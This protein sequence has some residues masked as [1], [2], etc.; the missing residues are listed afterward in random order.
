[1]AHRSRPTALALFAALTVTAAAIAQQPHPA[2][3]GRPTPNLQPAAAPDP[4]RPPM[5]I[6][7]V[8]FAGGTVQEFVKVIQK[9]AMESTAKTPVNVM[10]PTEAGA[11]SLPAISLKR[12]SAE[13]AL[14]T[15]R[16]AFGVQGAHQLEA[17][18]M[19]N[20]GDEGLTFA[21]QYAPGRSSPQMQGVQ[22]QQP[23]QSEA[24]S[25]REL[26]SVPEGL[27][28]DNDSLRMTPDAVLGAL[29]LAAELESVNAT[30]TP[31]QLLYHPDTQLLIA[32]GTPDQHRLISSILRQLA[33]MLEQ[34]RDQHGDELSRAHHNELQILE[35]K[36]QAAAA[37][38]QVQRA[39]SELGPAT[40]ELER[41]EKLFQAGS[42]SASEVERA[43]ANLG[44]A[45]ANLQG[46]EVQM[47]TLEQRAEVLQRKAKAD[48]MPAE[49]QE[50]IVVIYDVRDLANFKADFYGL[51]KQVI[52]PDGKMSIKAASGDPTG[53]IVVHA[54]RP[55]HEILVA[56]FNTARRLKT[57]E[58]KLPG[59]TLDTLIEQS[60]E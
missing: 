46:A 37:Q 43:R 58:P 9:A 48:S 6:I 51:V 55:Q 31:T 41:I 28:A 21:I 32:R 50:P 60:K 11:I 30:T 33:D 13:T 38:A 23:I 27:P 1:M 4:N 15:L 56:I 34:R 25:L 24:Y 42:A 47:Q 26:I 52:K 35:L 54:T 3:P 12:V 19:T 17:R 7:D 2:V 20:P 5:P 40:A 45:Q 14:E 39:R 49:R 10:I 18:N 8:D 53:I 22:M 57:N 44:V 59:Q 16:Y 36:A 29:K